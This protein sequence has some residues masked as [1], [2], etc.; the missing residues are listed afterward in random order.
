MI[1]VN[2]PFGQDPM[3]FNENTSADRVGLRI[4]E[5][6]EAQ[7]MTQAELGE[8]IGLNGDRVQKYENGVRKPKADLLKKF[9]SA[10]CWMVC[11]SKTPL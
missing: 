7:G 4:R 5:I 11:L 3:D 8:K 6:R 1:V 9:A 10:F 2:N